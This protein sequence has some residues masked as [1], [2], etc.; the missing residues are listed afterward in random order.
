MFAEQGEVL[1]YSAVE[2]ATKLGNISKLRGYLSQKKNAKQTT[3]ALLGDLKG[4]SI[5]LMKKVY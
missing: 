5:A 3:I 2:Y 4:F 1:S